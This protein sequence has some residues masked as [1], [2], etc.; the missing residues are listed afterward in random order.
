MP[1]GKPVVIYTTDL[2]QSLADGL[3]RE[4]PVAPAPGVAEPQM[5]TDVADTP[6]EMP[7]PEGPMTQVRE[8]DKAP[9]KAPPRRRRPSH[10]AEA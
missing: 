6:P 4:P 10:P 5:P 7:A 9:R 3:L 2:K 8:A 1:D